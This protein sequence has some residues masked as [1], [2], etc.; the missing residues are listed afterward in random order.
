MIPLV[1]VDGLIQQLGQGER[2]TVNRLNIGEWENLFAVSSTV[3]VSS[4]FVR[5]RSNSMQDVDTILGGEEGDVLVL[6]G[7]NIRLRRI[8]GGNLRLRSSITML[9]ANRSTLLVYTG[10]FWVQPG[11]D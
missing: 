2:L 5:L 11:G 7:N 1:I 3:T 10:S 8:P 4:S 9:N 6:F